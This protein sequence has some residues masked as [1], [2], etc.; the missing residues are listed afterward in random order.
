MSQRAAIQAVEQQRWFFLHQ[1]LA[2][3]RF[4][5]QPHRHTPGAHH[6]WQGAAAQRWRQP[7]P[8]LLHQQIGATAA[9][10]TALAAAQQHIACAGLACLKP[11][12]HHGAVVQGF[13]AVQG[14]LRPALHAFADHN[15]LPLE[16]RL[17]GIQA[18]PAA[19][20]CLQG[21]LQAAAAAAPAPVDPQGSIGNAAAADGFIDPLLH[22]LLIRWVRE[23]QPS[24]PIT[25][26]L[27][28][29]KEQLRPSCSNQ[30]GFKHPIGQAEAAITHR[31]SQRVGMA[32]LLL[33]PGDGAAH[34]NSRPAEE[35]ALSIPVLRF[36]GAGRSRP[37]CRN[38]RGRARLSR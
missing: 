5:D 25:P 33:N 22:L 15:L 28:M 17:V 30:Q 3:T 34:L 2:Q 9:A 18:A 32:P 11:G 24:C 19:T 6:A 10:K 13:A 31:H 12:Q 20:F 16:A 4:L 26:A 29:L 37:R 21:R 8:A 35:V 23:L 7:L 1:R 36:Q 14:V 38:R 27:Q